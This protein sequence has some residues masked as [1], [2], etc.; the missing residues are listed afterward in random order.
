MEELILHSFDAHIVTLFLLYIY[1]KCN[2]KTD[3]EA[4]QYMRNLSPQQFLEH[5]KDIRIAAFSRD[6]YRNANQRTLDHSEP[7][8]NGY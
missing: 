4:E 8:A 3:G 7:P 2:I 6:I 1:N 5:I